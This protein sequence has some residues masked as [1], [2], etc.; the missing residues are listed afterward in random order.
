MERIHKGA[1][2]LSGLIAR[3]NNVAERHA[4]TAR[5]GPLWQAYFAEHHGQLADGKS[6][7]GVY[8][9]YQSDMNG[10]Y[11]V[12]VGTLAAS[13]DMSDIRLAEG[14]YL[15]FSASGEMPDCV[16][17]LWAEIWRYFT[18]PECQYQRSYLSDYEVYPDTT[19]VEIYIGIKS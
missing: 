12:L 14:D 6:M 18:S 2:A 8:H 19:R 4:E 17:E 11:S 13:D 15:M 7:Y 9:D 5:I 3:T 16:V 1:L 10:D